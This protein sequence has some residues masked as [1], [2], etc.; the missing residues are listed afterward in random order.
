MQSRDPKERFSSRVEAYV[1]YRPGYPEEII[2]YLRDR[3]DLQRDSVVADI[4]SGTGIFTELLLSNGN[5]VYAVEPNDAMRAAAEKRFEANPRY[6]SVAA[7]AEKTALDDA[8]VDMVTCAHAF[9]WFEPQPTRREFVRI[10]KPGGPVVLI[11][12]ARLT[13]TTPFLAAYERFLLEY[14]SDYRKVNHVNVERDRLDSFYSPSTY[15]IRSF[16]NEQVFDFDGLRGLVLSS[17]YMP[18]P[19]SPSFSAMIDALKVLFERHEKAGAVR[20]EYSTNVYCGRLR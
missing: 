18:G 8:A 16:P 3:Y 9:H 14:A 2:D 6:S 19:E 20:I 5:T 4:G 15:T 13:D 10:L 17:S 11:W 7:S 1:R 12:N